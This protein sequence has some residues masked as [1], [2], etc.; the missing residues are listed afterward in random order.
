[1]LT[2]SCGMWDVLP[3]QSSLHWE[4]KVL[5]TGPPGKSC[6]YECLSRGKILRGLSLGEE[7]SDCSAEKDQS[8]QDMLKSGEW[9]LYLPDCRWI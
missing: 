9:R 2:V 4:R 7:D 3:D 6:L 1:M 8:W 5:V